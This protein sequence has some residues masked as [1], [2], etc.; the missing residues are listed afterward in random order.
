[1]APRRRHLSVV[2]GKWGG[3]KG[4]LQYH[5]QKRKGR[6]EPVLGAADIFPP[7]PPIFAYRQTAKCY[8]FPPVLNSARTV[9]G[10]EGGEMLLGN[11]LP[12]AAT[13]CK[14]RRRPD[15]GIDWSEPQ[16]SPEQSD[17]WTHAA[18][19]RVS[20]GI[21]NRPVG[22]ICQRLAPDFR[23]LNL[24]LQ[25]RGASLAH[26]PSHWEPQVSI[27]KPSKGPFAGAQR[28][29]KHLAWLVLASSFPGRCQMSL[30]VSLKYF[31]CTA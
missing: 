24:V 28:T 6:F 25:A 16:V 20:S 9:L 8:S 14:V 12:E 19:Q 27:T 21:I 23:L 15:R 5:V 2:Q 3:G 17:G 18:T 10:V 1:M 7:T 11:R 22:A 26:S 13:T 29:R 4:E 30:S 31:F